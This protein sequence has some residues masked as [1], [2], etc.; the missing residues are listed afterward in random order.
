MPSK[1]R[2]S[3]FLALL[4]LLLQVGACAGSSRGSAATPAK[5]VNLDME[6]TRVEVSRDAKGG[7][8]V[9]AYDARELFD[10]AGA[11]LDASRHGEALALYDRL[12]A[13]FPDSQ[14]VPPALFNAGLALEGEGKLD[15]AIA[16][17]LEV[18][19]RTPATRHG[20]DAHIR[21]AAVMAELSRWRDSL[22]ELDRLLARADLVHADRV[23]VQ[24]RRGHVLVERGSYAEA[25]TALAAAIDLAR[26]GQR[27]IETDYF[28][29]MAHYY[30]GE[31]QRR[32]ADAVR[33]EL[34][35]AALEQGIESKAK[36]VLAAQRRFEDT[37]RLG[38]LYWAT[39]AGYQ[40]GAMQQEV[41]RALRAAPV[42]R[43][44]KADEAA[45]YTGEVRTLA[46]AHL[47]KALA[48]HVMNVKVAEHHKQQT[49]W[50]E[51]SRQ[52][53][54]ELT[55]IIASESRAPAG[56]APAQTSTP[57]PA[58]PTAPRPARPRHHVPRRI[59]R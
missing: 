32:Q 35:E 48:A 37:I 40:L 47:D 21:A 30:Q 52:R 26:R 14:L 13:S 44:L 59:D 4:A 53:I 11:A 33:L 25:E 50:S 1:T 15:A 49:P 55:A 34:P 57:R 43:R 17:Y 2:S 51:S 6:P 20:L 27:R 38:N 18:V 23:E 3:R 7:A 22:R 24:A 29:A 42:P 12:V 45:I 41:W 54:S 16:R 5:V 28:A 58:D 46:R 9:A 10:R 8:Q 31:V 56:G 39:A 19:R 36:L